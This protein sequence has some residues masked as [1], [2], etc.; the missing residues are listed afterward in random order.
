[1]C[2]DIYMGF[3]NGDSVVLRGC[4]REVEAIYPNPEWQ[5][6]NTSN[7]RVFRTRRGYCGL[8]PRAAQLNDMVCVLLEGK[9]P[10]ILRKELA[11]GIK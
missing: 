6:L 7:R 4:K 3:Q 5:K 10:Y 1:M 2:A 9:V 11:F 8:V